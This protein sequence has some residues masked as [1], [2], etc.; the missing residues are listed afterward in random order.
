MSKITKASIT[1]LYP[2][3]LFLGKY[4]IIDLWELL[5]VLF[6]SKNFYMLSITYKSTKYYIV[7]YNSDR[8][9]YFIDF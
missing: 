1:K 9:S 6:L 8:K 5:R 4:I 7:V 3:K 2:K